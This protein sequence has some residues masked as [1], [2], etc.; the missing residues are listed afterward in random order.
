MT[1]ISQITTNVRIFEIKYDIMSQYEMSNL[2]KIKSYLV[3]EFIRSQEGLF[4]HQ[5][6]S[7]PKDFQAKTAKH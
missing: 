3:V 2:E 5:K 4:M 1:Y 7:Y 6:I